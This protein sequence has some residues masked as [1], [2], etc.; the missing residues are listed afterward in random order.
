MSLWPEKYVG[1]PFVDGGRNFKGVD[2][3]GLVRLVLQHECNIEVPSY[4]EISAL[5]LLKVAGVVAA[6]SAVEPWVQ[7]E[8][9]VTFDVAVMHRRQTPIHVGIMV[10]PT[11]VLHIEKACSTVLIP[12][13]HMSI[14]FR[15]TKF[16]RHRALL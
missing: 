5:D 2:C 15:P 13:T 3:W 16:Y 10:T 9:P 6:E 14:S 12:I 1:L 7:I 8:K 4:G 11:E